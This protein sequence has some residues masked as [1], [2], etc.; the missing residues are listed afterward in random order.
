MKLKQLSLALFAVCGGLASAPA[1]ALPASQYTNA[2]E[3]SGDTLNIRIS[4][5][6]A[7]DAGVLG[8][9]LSYC[10][11]GT[12]HRFQISNNFA[13]F[14]TPDIGT[15]A[16]QIQ[17]PAGRTKVAIY[18]YA[19]GGSGSGVDPV[20]LNQTLPFLDLAK[21]ATSP[22][23]SGTNLTTSTPDFDG[24]GPL[25]TYVNNV[26]GGASSLLTTGATTYIGLSDVEPAFFTNNTANL[27]ST[28]L[29]TLIFGVPVSLNI[30]NALQTQQGLTV[31]SDTEANMPSLTSAQI[32][33]AYT[34]AGQSWAGIGVTSG[35]ADDTIYV[36]RRVN[37]SGTQ[38]TYEALFAKTPNGE[39]AFKSC[40]PGNEPFVQPDSGT[41]T[42]DAAALCASAPPLVFA[43]SGGGDVRTCMINHH[44]NNR[45][46]IG[47][48][49]GE[50]KPG[51]ANWRFVKL[52]GHAPT[53][54]NVAA[55]RYTRYTDASF[56]VRVNVNPTSSALGYTN[57]VNRF[58]LDLANPTIIGLING[59]DQTFGPSGLMVSYVS[60]TPDFTGANRVNPWN[61]LVGGTAIDNC[62]SPKAPF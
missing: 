23:C 52:D 62:Q 32:T 24:T 29:S 56:N 40:Y 49:T 38:K 53:H 8:S 54:A 20:N 28:P 12:L 19:V 60:G 58:K 5:A 34:Q 17:V 37:S 2:S 26:C 44:N 36:A 51:S 46:A 61:R 50:D 25:A 47:I 14:C 41:T 42:G 6:S 3:F 31:G 1:F 15:G 35:L 7:Q 43:G 9:A 22:A 59:S 16:G 10:V 30:R 21:I 11:A 4:G 55:G 18:K 27:S 33:S 48:L 57:F 45:G 13:F 39:P